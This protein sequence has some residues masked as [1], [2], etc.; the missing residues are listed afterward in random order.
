MCQ[1]TWWR[2]KNIR[3]GLLPFQGSLFRKKANIWTN[4]CSSM[5]KKSTNSLR[6]EEWIDLKNAPQRDG[7]VCTLSA[8]CSG[9]RLIFSLLEKNSSLSVGPKGETN[10]IIEWM[11]WM[12]WRLLPPSELHLV[13]WTGPEKGSDTGQVA[14]QCPTNWKQIRSQVQSIRVHRNVTWPTTPFFETLSGQRL[15]V[16]QSLLLSLLSYWTRLMDN[17]CPLP[18]AQI[19]Y[20]LS[21]TNCQWKKRRTHLPIFIAF[22]PFWSVAAPSTPSRWFLWPVWMLYTRQMK[23]QWPRPAKINQSPCSLASEHCNAN[24]FTFSAFSGTFSASLFNEIPISTSIALAFNI[25]LR[26]EFNQ[27]FRRP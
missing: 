4:I 21:H 3:L 18:A 2:L 5:W 22:D 25:P 1:L 13:K 26:Y 15:V 6:M 20:P 27:H 23:Q 7:T 16:Y 17:Q 10:I 24:I 11:R 19:S 9:F 12:K 8:E 14:S